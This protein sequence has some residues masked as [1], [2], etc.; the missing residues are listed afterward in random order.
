MPVVDR[1]SLVEEPTFVVDEA[2]EGSSA[3]KV[4]PSETVLSEAGNLVSMEASA[5]VEVSTALASCEVLLGVEVSMLEDVEG[6]MS[7]N[8]SLTITVTESTV[9]S[10]VE[11]EVTV[12]SSDDAVAESPIV[13]DV[14]SLDV[15]CGSVALF[16]PSDSV[17]CCVGRTS[18]REEDVLSGITGSSP[19][20]VPGI[21]EG[22]LKLVMPGD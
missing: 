2:L 4:L 13:G 10:A 14:S 12:A 11:A 1:V 20:D 17:P 19:D 21:E 5:S 3:V 9:D 8:D 7:V 15:L 6:R 22:V 16:S 18:T